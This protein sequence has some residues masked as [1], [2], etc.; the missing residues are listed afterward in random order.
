[1]PDADA[2]RIEKCRGAFDS[3]SGRCW[4]RVEGVSGMDARSLR[5]IA[6]GWLIVDDVGK[7]IPPLSVSDQRVDVQRNT[8][9]GIQIIRKVGT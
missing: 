8:L 1:M 5:A 4:R 3:I 6:V 9:A 2:R 7:P